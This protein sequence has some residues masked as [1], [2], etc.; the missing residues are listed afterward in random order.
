MMWEECDK[1]FLIE[2][3]WKSD[4]YANKCTKQQEKFNYYQRNG[5]EW[6]WEECI[7]AHQ[8][9]KETGEY[10]LIMEAWRR[11]ELRHEARTR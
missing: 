3:I 10:W 5:I 9:L 7:A 2:L 6:T 1:D 4:M 8:I 11:G